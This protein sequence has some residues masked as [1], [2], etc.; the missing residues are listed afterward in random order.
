MSVRLFHRGARLVLV[1]RRREVETAAAGAPL[2]DHRW[3]AVH[4]AD[5]PWDQLFRNALGL[6]D[7]SAAP[8][9]NGVDFGDGAGEVRWTR[10][11]FWTHIEV[12]LFRGALRKRQLVA[13]AL[14]K[15]ARYQLE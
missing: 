11:R 13:Q 6:L 5:H 14:L 9:A 8:C 1:L 12:R 4:R 7:I 15:T 2:G 10:G 3:L